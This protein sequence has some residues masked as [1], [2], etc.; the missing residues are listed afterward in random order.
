MHED[1]WHERWRTGQIGFHQAEPDRNL[2]QYW[3]GLAL[4]TGSSVLVPLCGK[5]LDMLWLRD[6]GYSVLGIEISAIAVEAFFAENG[7]APR[8]SSA[9]D[10]EIY[11]SAGLRLLRADLFSLTKAS[12]GPIDGLY[13][14]AAAI[15]FSASQRPGYVEKVASLL[16]RGTRG[17]LV[18]V[19]Y[20][21]QQMSGPPFSLE[22]EEVLRLY[23]PFFEVEE[24]ARADTLERE[25]RMR[26]RGVTAWH[27]V[28]YRLVRA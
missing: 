15:A 5:S 8:R 19:E 28:C 6:R 17:L 4:A 25:H 2:T 12:L 13:D 10:H 26:A 27:E 24:I 1:F 7:I 20:S 9:P 11:R 16:E 22:R 14:R 23:S 18:T 3:P 21:Q